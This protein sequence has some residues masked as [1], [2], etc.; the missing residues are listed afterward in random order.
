MLPPA[1]PEDLPALR[2][3][4]FV[5]NQSRRLPPSIAYEAATVSS[6]RRCGLLGGPESH[7]G[8]PIR[9]GLTGLSAEHR[10]CVIQPVCVSERLSVRAET[11]A[12]SCRIL[13]W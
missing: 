6:D 4:A 12:I 3:S 10:Q 8:S 7:P 1:H 13:A 9:D 11:S 5:G 2:S